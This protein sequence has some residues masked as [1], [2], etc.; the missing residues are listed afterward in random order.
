MCI[1][2]MFGESDTYY[3][4]IKQIKPVTSGDVPSIY[5]TSH[6]S[7]N[8]FEIPYPSLEDL[9]FFPL[10]SFGFWA[11]EVTN[12]VW[13]CQK[14]TWLRYQL[15]WCDNEVEQK[16]G[17]Y[18]QKWIVYIYTGF[19]GIYVNNHYCRLN[20]IQLLS[21]TRTKL[22]IGNQEIKHVIV[23]HFDFT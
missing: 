4:N 16:S 21:I 14:V 11:C 6:I 12:L 2:C 9:W 5:L 13:F 1:S 10:G 20:Q 23:T 17:W 3:Q 19:V 7:V 8:Q 18:C 22:M 15:T